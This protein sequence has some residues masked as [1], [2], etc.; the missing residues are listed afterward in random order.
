M[1][2]QRITIPEV[3][4][5][6]PNLFSNTG[7]MNLI[8]TRKLI[9]LVL[10]PP[11]HFKFNITHPTS[12]TNG[13]YTEFATY[14]GMD[15]VLNGDEQTD[16]HSITFNN[17]FGIEVTVPSDE[18][19]FVNQNSNF[20]GNKDTTHIHLNFTSQSYNLDIGRTYD[21]YLESLTTTNAVDNKDKSR[22]SFILKFNEFNILNSSNLIPVNTIIIPNESTS[23]SGTFFHKSKKLNY[24]TTI[25]PNTLNKL[26]GSISTLDGKTI[27]TTPHVEKDTSTNEY[28]VSDRLI[29]ELVLIEKV[30][31]T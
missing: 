18:I 7:A 9:T 3:E 10:S 19:I 31:I 29:I 1:Y 24:I 12:T 30:K 14:F 21:V 17:T 15:K 2:G 26:T 8:N 11:T 25:T 20:I 16:I 22:S 6:N 27:F 23:S 28:T 4:R 13:E 5:Q